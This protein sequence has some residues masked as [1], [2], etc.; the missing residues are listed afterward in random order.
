MRLLHEVSEDGCRTPLSTKQRRK[1]WAIPILVV[2]VFVLGTPFLVLGSRQEARKVVGVP[3][4]KGT[5]VLSPLDFGQF[6][7]VGP[8]ILVANKKCFDFFF[9]GQSTQEVRAK[10]VNALCC[11]QVVFFSE[12][13]PTGNPQTRG[14]YKTKHSLFVRSLSLCLLF[15]GNPQ[16]RNRGEGGPKPINPQ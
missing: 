3:Y 7:G 1:I 6:C 13:N 4:K 15:M 16:P 12:G 5:H 14:A 11:F 2:C 8:T 10:P 9:C